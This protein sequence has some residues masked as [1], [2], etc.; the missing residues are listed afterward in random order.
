MNLSD[1]MDLKLVNQTDKRVLLTCKLDLPHK[2]S[3]GLDERQPGGVKE[4][5]VGV[6]VNGA[7]LAGVGVGVEHDVEA[8]AEGHDEEG[9]PQ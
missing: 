6:G 3:R 1:L 8:E 9:V 7:A 4:V 2:H 5:V